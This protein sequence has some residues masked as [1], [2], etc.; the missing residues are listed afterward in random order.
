MAV[1]TAAGTGRMGREGA[2]PRPAQ[3]GRDGIHPAEGNGLLD[4]GT[5]HIQCSILDRA[6]GGKHTATKVSG[7]QVCPYGQYRM[8]AVSTSVGGVARLKNC[9]ARWQSFV[10]RWAD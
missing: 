4:F 2:E 10:R 9:F 7:C 6:G 1:G 8:A 3:P 5:H